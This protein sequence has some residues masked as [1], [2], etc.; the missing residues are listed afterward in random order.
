MWYCKCEKCGKMY[1]KIY[2]EIHKNQFQIQKF[3][4]DIREKYCYNPSYK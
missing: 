3:T 1:E 2:V 4:I